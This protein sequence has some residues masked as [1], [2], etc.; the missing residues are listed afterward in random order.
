MVSVVLKL[1][2]SPE[3]VHALE[4]KYTDKLGGEAVVPSPEVN[5][6]PFMK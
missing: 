5:S 3:A 2:P 4:N 1:E 6:R